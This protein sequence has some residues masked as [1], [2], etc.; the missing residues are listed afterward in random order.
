MCPLSQSSEFSFLFLEVLKSNVRVRTRNDE[1][2]DTHCLIHFVN[3]FRLDLS[4]NNEAFLRLAVVRAL[5]VVI[6]LCTIG[7]DRFEGVRFAHSVARTFEKIMRVAA[8]VRVNTK[9]IAQLKRANE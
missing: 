3:I 8:R 4:G 9:N 6:E 1:E 2:I 5:R 7:V